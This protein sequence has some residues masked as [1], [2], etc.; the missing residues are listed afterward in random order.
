MAIEDAVC[1]ADHFSRR[2][3]DLARA[4][5]DYER[6]RFARTSRIQVA[7]REMGRLNHLA[8]EAA[9]A[10]DEALAT[11]DPEDHE[12]S[13]WIFDGPKATAPLETSSYFG[14]VRP[15]T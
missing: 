7:A 1:L 3:P 2:A 4:C 10:R 12:G 11:R 8:G 13:A 14:S 15:G 6:E 5:L 9:R